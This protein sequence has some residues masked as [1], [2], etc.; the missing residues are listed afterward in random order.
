MFKVIDDNHM[1][2]YSCHNAM[3]R[4]RDSGISVNVQLGDSA[5]DISYS[6]RP[7]D[8]CRSPVEGRRYHCRVLDIT[9]DQRFGGSIKR[10]SPHPS[11]AIVE[12]FST[13]FVRWWRELRDAVGSAFASNSPDS[14]TDAVNSA[15]HGP[16]S[17]SL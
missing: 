11:A 8:C 12:E 16:D 6:D 5:R 15:D 17:L 14:L 7:C 2:C 3:S 4:G 9:G 1:V 13:L 10:T